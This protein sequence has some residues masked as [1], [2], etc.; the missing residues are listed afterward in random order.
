MPAFK[1]FKTYSPLPYQELSKYIDIET[2][3]VWKVNYN[4]ISSLVRN[5]ISPLLPF[6]PLSSLVSFSLKSNSF[7]ETSP[8]LL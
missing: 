1:A 8:K 7:S 2:K 5:Y 4:M 3:V 6:L